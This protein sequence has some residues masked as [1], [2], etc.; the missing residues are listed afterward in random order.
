VDITHNILRIESLR[1]KAAPIKLGCGEKTFVLKSG[2][3]KELKF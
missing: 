3:T 1:T 2:E